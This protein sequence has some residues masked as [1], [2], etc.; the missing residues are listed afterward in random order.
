VVADVE[1]ELDEHPATARTDKAT[2][3]ETP[4]IKRTRV[5]WSVLF[6][7]LSVRTLGIAKVSFS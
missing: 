6:M 5:R 4:A 3:P 7:A 2:A 1:L